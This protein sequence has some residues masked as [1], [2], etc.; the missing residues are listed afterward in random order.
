M[1]ITTIPCL[2]K[3]MKNPLKFFNKKRITTI[4]FD[5]IDSMCEAFGMEK[6]K[7]VHETFCTDTK[8]QVD[9]NEFLRK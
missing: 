8:I 2:L 3:L 5:E 1:L 4:V 9:Y 6:V 7:L